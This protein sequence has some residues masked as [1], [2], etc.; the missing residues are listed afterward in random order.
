MKYLKLFEDLEEDNSKYLIQLSSANSRGIRGMTNPPESIKKDA[1]EWWSLS[2]DVIVKLE[3]QSRYQNLPNDILTKLIGCR[4]DI[5]RFGPC[6]APQAVYFLSY[7]RDISDL[8]EQDIKRFR[9]NG[10][11]DTKCTDAHNILSRVVKKFK[12]M[13]IEQKISYFGELESDEFL[14]IRNSYIYKVVDGKDLMD[15]VMSISGK[16]DIISQK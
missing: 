2:V 12:R 9:Y 3:I 5:E 10:I 4:T 13:D 16:L 6:N 1:E 8:S 14:V 15:E 11:T 7:L